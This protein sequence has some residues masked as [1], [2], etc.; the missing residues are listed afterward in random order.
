[1]MTKSPLVQPTN[2]L[3]KKILTEEELEV[4]QAKQKAI[5]EALKD[6]AY[7]ISVT[8]FIDGMKWPHVLPIM[9]RTIANTVINIRVC[10]SCQTSLMQFTPA[11]I[12]SFVSDDEKGKFSIGADSMPPHDH[13]WIS[14]TIHFDNKQDEILTLCEICGVERSE[15]TTPLTPEKMDE[16]TKE[17]LIKHLV[18]IGVGGWTTKLNKDK[19]IDLIV[20]SYE[21]QV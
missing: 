15:V 19:L 18:T 4:Q 10:S 11:K 16:M 1:M 8:C 9:T 17:Q 2:Q 13:K 3:K 21:D 7:V 14:R 6:T 20:D 12:T 5:D